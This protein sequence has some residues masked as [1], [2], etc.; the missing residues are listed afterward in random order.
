MI[1]LDAS[2]GIEIARR[3]PH[4]LA[5][6]RRLL[7]ESRPYHIPHL[8]DLE[9]AQTVRR[10]VLAQLLSPAGGSAALRA[11]SLLPLERHA[12]TPLLGRVWQLRDNLTAYDASYVALA[13]ALD[14]TLLTRDARLAGAPGVRARV[15]VV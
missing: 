3:T 1:V 5:A 10:Y 14:A 13:E 12:H 7:R 6:A 9:V 8:F 11:L 4:G 15:E 2:V